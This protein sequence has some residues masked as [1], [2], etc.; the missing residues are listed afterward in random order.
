M[1]WLI[2]RNAMINQNYTISIVSHGH[3]KLIS[4]LLGDLARVNT[5]NMHLILT[6][7]C[8]EDEAFLAGLVGLDYQIIRNTAPKGFGANHNAAFS[9][10]NGDVFVVMNPDV[11]WPDGFEMN[12][13]VDRFAASG[14]GVC[15]PLVKSGTGSIEDS[16]RYF[17]SLSRLMVRHL[18]GIR[19]PDYCATGS[20]IE[21]EWVAGIMLALRREAF[22]KVG[23]FDERYFMYLEDTDLCRRIGRAGWTVI[24]DTRDA[25]IHDAQRASH[26]QW[27]HVSWHVRSMLRFLASG[28]LS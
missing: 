24:Y 26:R 21:V 7:N 12:K 16:A 9:R 23:G 4:H 18:R 22:V 15:G 27:A 17:P 11:R 28:Y 8:P 5:A 10:S 25:I 14:A 3:G 19:T 6:L 1:L 13:F 2:V 20:S